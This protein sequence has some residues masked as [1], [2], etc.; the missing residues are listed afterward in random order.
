VQW[1]LTNLLARTRR[2][3]QK[4]PNSPSGRSDTPLGGQGVCL[5]T[6]VL[7]AMLFVRR[8]RLVILGIVALVV[9]KI[10]T[11][12]RRNLSPTCKISADGYSFEFLSYEYI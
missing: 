11:S 4:Y 8:R 7:K 6:G 5:Q 9:E 12:S 1:L 3:N 10:R 2:N